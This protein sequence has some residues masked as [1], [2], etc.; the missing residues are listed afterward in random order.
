MN[1]EARFEKGQEVVSAD[2]PS[3]RYRVLVE[4][5]DHADDIVVV[6]RAGNYYIKHQNDDLEP[7]PPAVVYSCFLNFYSQRVGIS[8]PTAEEAR[9][10]WYDSPAT[11]VR[12][13]YMSDGSV[14][15]EEIERFTP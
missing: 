10:V 7:V 1:A 11:L 13:D 5:P 12:L 9:Q 14:Q 15:L 2:D 6:D 4:T 3:R 8:R